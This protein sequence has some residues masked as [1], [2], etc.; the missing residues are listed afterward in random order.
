[1]N[2]IVIV[3][4]V[5]IV[6][7]GLVTAAGLLLRPRTVRTHPAEHTHVTVADLQARLAEEAERLHPNAHSDDP[8]AALRTD[9]AH[10][11]TDG[12]GE[13]TGMADGEAGGVGKHSD[14]PHDLSRSA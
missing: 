7:V 13:H 11:G 6:V 5:L 2:A 3:T 9:P 8:E 10:R 14:G 12:V 4:V 1:M